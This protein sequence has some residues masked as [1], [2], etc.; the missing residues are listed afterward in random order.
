MA[1]A[2]MAQHKD[3]EQVACGPDLERRSV[4]EYDA[5]HTHE[6]YGRTYQHRGLETLAEHGGGQECGEYRR[7][8][9][10]Q[11][12]VGRGGERKCVVLG[13]EV[14]RAGTDAAQSHCHFIAQTV[15]EQMPACEQQQ[16]E[17][18]GEESVE[19]DFHRSHLGLAHQ[20][21]GT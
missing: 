10:Q 18:G 9:R 14:K 5:S 16:Y 8:G 15:T 17:I 12:H 4:A 20:N 13:D 3:A 11:R 19:I 6:R 1:M 21:F 2:Y 7:D